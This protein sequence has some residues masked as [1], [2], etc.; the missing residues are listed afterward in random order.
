MT[1][2]WNLIA[3]SALILVLPNE[4][5]S[6]FWAARAQKR[7]VSASYVDGGVTSDDDAEAH[8]PSVRCA[9]TSPR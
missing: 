4:V 3:W 6:A 1:F 8:D 2:D 9:D 7:G 5:G